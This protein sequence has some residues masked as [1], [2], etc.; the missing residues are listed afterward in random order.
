MTRPDETD[1]AVVAPRARPLAG[2][3]RAVTAL[4][5]QAAGQTKQGLRSA[6]DDRYAIDAEPPPRPQ[7]FGALNEPETCG[8]P[9]V[10][11]QWSCI[12]DDY[13]RDDHAEAEGQMVGADGEFTVG[14]ER[15]PYPG[16]LS[17][18]NRINCGCIALTVLDDDNP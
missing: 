14:G 4:V 3:D 15:C 18:A 2:E 7:V 11:K 5:I 9:Q 1:R 17:P 13:P 8:L 12:M 10:G 6:N 16:A